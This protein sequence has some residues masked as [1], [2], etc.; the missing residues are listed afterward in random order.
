[1]KNA[2]LIEF[3]LHEDHECTL[4]MIYYSSWEIN[5]KAYGNLLQSQTMYENEIYA[6]FKL[7]LFSATYRPW[8]MYEYNKALY[9]TM[10]YVYRLERRLKCGSQSFIFDRWSRWCF[11]VGLGVLLLGG[12]ICG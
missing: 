3:Y 1:M 5:K 7:D 11:L 9:T 12:H 4:F 8:P 10:L 2:Q 6:F